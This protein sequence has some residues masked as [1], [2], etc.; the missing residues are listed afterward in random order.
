[1]SGAVLLWWIVLPYVATTIFVVGHIWRWR[2][3][4]FGWT[5]RS[6]QLQES[7]LLKVG[8]PLFHYGALAAIAGHVLGILIPSSWTAAVG[9][10]EDDYHLLSA[11]AGTGAGILVV[12][13]LAI[14]IYRRVAVPRVAATTSR[15][16][17]ATYVLLVLVIVLGFGETL[18]VNALGPR[19]RLP[20]HGGHLVPRSLPARPGAAAHDRRAAR[21]PDPRHE[22]LVPVRPLAVQPPR[23][24]MERALGVL[25]S[26]VDPLPE[27][28]GSGDQPARRLTDLERRWTSRR[29]TRSVATYRTS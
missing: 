13:G 21:L 7:R 14:L 29:A 15:T 16:D 27:P 5:T 28:S 11:V 3:D 8:G 12:V 19:L 18:L 17:A 9:I 24:C 26:A 23:P 10:T 1:M 22:R 6:S 2:H 4:Q 25:R 20:F